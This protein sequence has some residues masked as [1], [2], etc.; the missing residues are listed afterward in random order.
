MTGGW[1]AFT[2]LSLPVSVSP[3]NASGGLLVSVIHYECNRL[4][5]SAEIE[6]LFNPF[7]P[8]TQKKEGAYWCPVYYVLHLHNEVI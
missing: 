7:L 8:V 5:I 3:T 1:S 6:L 2:A 4:M